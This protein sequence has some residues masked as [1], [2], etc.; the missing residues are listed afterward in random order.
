MSAQHRLAAVSI[1]LQRLSRQNL[2]GTASPAMTG[3]RL[4]VI[5]DEVSQIA[6]ELRPERRML[7]GWRRLWFWA[8]RRAVV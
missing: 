3:I 1:A 7:T 6:S 8:M 2:N 5:A 4:A